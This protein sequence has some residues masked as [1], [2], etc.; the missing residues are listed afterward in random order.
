MGTGYNV[1]V[2]VLPKGLTA[3]DLQRQV[4]ARLD[5]INQQMSTYLPESEISCFNRHTG[6]DWFPVS[7][8]TAF[9][10]SAALEISKQTDGAFDITVGPLVDLWGF[11]PGPRPGR[12]PA[13]EEI[14]AAKSRVGYERVAVRREPP[15]LRKSQPDVHLDLS[16]LGEGFAVDEV[17]ALLDRQGLVAYLV[18][19][20]GEMRA[21]GRKP[22]G[23]PWRI[24]IERPVR[25]VR[26]IHQVIELK[27]R[28]L[29][30]SGD[31]RNFFEWQGRYYS[32]EIDPKT[33]WP[34]EHALGSVSVLADQCMLADAWATALMV[35][36]PERALQS[37]ERHQLDVLLIV[38]QGDGFIE[39]ATPGFA[40]VR[41]EN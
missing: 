12:I 38:R 33:G 14:A 7:P 10:V 31:Y 17:A 13:P 9:V 5:T 4:D 36:G 32:H 39:Q 6:D 24:G 26:E 19:I 37:A 23:T 15:A 20:G 28:A 1:K 11:G 34:V 30:T 27:D 35:L 18:D 3:A 8:A 40:A 25:S 29:A 21:R 41:I 2:A 22:D 16:A